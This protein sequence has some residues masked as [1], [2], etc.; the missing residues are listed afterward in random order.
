MIRAVTERRRGKNGAAKRYKGERDLVGT[1]IPPAKKD[2]IDDAAAAEGACR[3]D[4]LIA[5]IEFGLAHP[6]QVAAILRQLRAQQPQLAFDGQEVFGE[7]A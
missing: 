4:W 1:R 5:A 7:S 2:E 3:S 6:A